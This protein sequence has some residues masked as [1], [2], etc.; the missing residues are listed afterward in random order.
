MFSY[1]DEFLDRIPLSTHHGIPVCFFE[2]RVPDVVIDLLIVQLLPYACIEGMSS[3][4]GVIAF[5]NGCFIL[6][7]SSEV[8]DVRITAD[9]LLPCLLHLRSEV[10]SRFFCCEV[11]G[12]ARQ[13]CE[14]LLT[15]GQVLKGEGLNHELFRPGKMVHRSTLAGAPDRV[16]I[17]RIASLLK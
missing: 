3:Y 10:L 7:Q 8:P 2:K 13:P 11:T 15:T 17:D 9:R 5:Q 6:K 1:L 14:N 12:R 4:G 16:Q